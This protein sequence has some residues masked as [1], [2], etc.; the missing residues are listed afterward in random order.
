MLLPPVFLITSLPAHPSALAAQ[1]HNPLFCSHSEE[2]SAAPP[3]PSARSAT[4]NEKLR[5][6]LHRAERRA[7]DLLHTL[8]KASEELEQLGAIG[9]SPS[10]LTAPGLGLIAAAGAKEEA[11][12]ELKESM[13]LHRLAQVRPS[14]LTRLVS[15]ALALT[16][17]GPNP[18]CHHIP[19]SLRGPKWPTR[20]P[21]INQNWP[22]GR[23]PFDQN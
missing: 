5:Q 1:C 13:A 19:D 6:Q 10:S 11:P 22:P 21:E 17:H 7:E 12:K 23:L 18:R 8:M 15:P 9:E 16:L 14:A 2:G 20:Q 4:T 3:S